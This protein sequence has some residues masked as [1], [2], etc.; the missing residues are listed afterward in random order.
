VGRHGPL[1]R[2]LDDRSGEPLRS[3]F[4]LLQPPSNPIEDWNNIIDNLQNLPSIP[5]LNQI[6]D[7]NNPMDNVDNTLDGP[8]NAPGI[9][10]WISTIIPV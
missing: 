2:H 3:V 7:Y 1:F 8:N 5:L 4:N 9:P 10:P 6:E